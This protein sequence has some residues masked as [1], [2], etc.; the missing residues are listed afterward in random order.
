LPG[1]AHADTLSFELSVHGQLLVVN[2]G[3]SCYGHSARRLQ[4]RGTAAHSTVQ[5]GGHNSSEVWSGF[6]VGRRARPLGVQVSTSQTGATEVR[7]SHD[8]YRWLPGKPLHTRAWRFL[9][10]GLEVEDQVS[11]TT[12]PAV[13]RYHLAPGLTLQADSPQVWLVQQ[14]G[15]TLARVQ[16]LRGQASDELSSFA[17]E[18]GQVLATRCLA[19]RCDTG[20]AL[21][22]WAW[23]SS[24]AV[25]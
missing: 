4:E 7:A 5:V 16:V 6:R 17:P 3:T 11:A 20:G 2:G 24:A 18:F 13:A 8:G 19:V 12:L 9:S 1:H 23:G 22:Q 14:E 21:T 15:V 25:T 10:S